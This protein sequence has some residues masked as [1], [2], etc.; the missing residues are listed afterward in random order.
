MRKNN[1]GDVMRSDTRFYL[2]RINCSSL[3]SFK[4]HILLAAHVSHKGNKGRHSPLLQDY[5]LPQ[6]TTEN[7]YLSTHSISNDLDMGILD[8]AMKTYSYQNG[9]RKTMIQTQKSD[10]MLERQRITQ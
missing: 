1:I 8:E 6:S 7:K 4:F 9:F 10:K 2:C 3:S 5:C